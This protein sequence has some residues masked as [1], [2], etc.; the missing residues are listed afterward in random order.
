M[1]M[2]RAFTDTFLRHLKPR[3]ERYDVTDPG[4]RGLQVRVYPSGQKSLQFRYH[5][6]GVVRRL[7]FGPYPLVTLAEAHFAHAKAAK[8]LLH[9]QDPAGVKISARLAE[10]AAGTV[11]ELA[12]EFMQRYVL[13][14]R[15]RPEQVQQMLDTNVLPF[16]RHRRAKDITPPSAPPMRR[17]KNPQM[18]TKNSS[19][20]AQPSRSGSQ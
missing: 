10:R 11:A 4:R 15:K 1:A 7:T 8:L 3:Q 14:E 18:P 6:N 20:S 9:G 19:G 17:K 2:R 12:E 5:Y 13:H 16:W